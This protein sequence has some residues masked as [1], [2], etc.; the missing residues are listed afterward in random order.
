MI[1]NELRRNLKKLRDDIPSDK[2]KIEEELIAKTL[3][4]SEIYINA[5]SLFIYNSFRSEVDTT[6]IIKEA[7][8]EKIV[9]LPVTNSLDHSM[10][11]YEIN[12]DSVFVQDSYGIQIPDTKTSNIINPKEIDLTIVPLLAYDNLGNRLGYGGGYYDRYLPRLR[13]DAIVVGIAY[14]N[15]F[16]EELTVEDFDKKLDYV[17]TVKYE[18]DRAFGEMKKF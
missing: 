4:N 17:V 8:N 15:Q 14:S 11:A 13:E 2:R 6:Y 1:K 16:V 18:E 10:E 3:L 9:G 7:L 5:K 12:E